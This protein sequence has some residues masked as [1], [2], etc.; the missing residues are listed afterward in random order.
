MS[1]LQSLFY[2]ETLDKA[3]RDWRLL[4]LDGYR[5]A[6]NQSYFKRLDCLVDLRQSIRYAHAPQS[7]KLHIDRLIEVIEVGS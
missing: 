2:K 4:A 6:N 5:V 7:N 1:W 3:K